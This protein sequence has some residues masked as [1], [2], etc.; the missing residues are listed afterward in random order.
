MISAARRRQRPAAVAELGEPREGG[1]HVLEG[2]VA[3]AVHAGRALMKRFSRTD[4]FEMSGLGHVADAACD[5]VGRR[6]VASRPCHCTA[7]AGRPHIAHQ[8]PSCPS[9][10]RA[11][12]ASAGSSLSVTPRSTVAVG[13]VSASSCPS[14]H[15]TASPEASCTC[16]LLRM[17]SGRSL[18]SPCPPI[19]VMRSATGHR[20][21]AGTAWPRFRRALGFLGAHAGERLVEQHACG[22]VARHIA[23]STCAAVAQ[24]AGRARARRGRRRRAPLVGDRA[25]LR[26]GRRRAA[27][28]P[29][30]AARRP[31]RTGARSR[32]RWNSLK[33]VVRW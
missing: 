26:A 8:R 3:P 2:P 31:G 11:G 28:T 9:S 27:H 13:R 5:C 24:H 20:R 29:R 32:T 12:R 15:A 7:P 33:M 19:T 4:R 6:A 30:R 22:L 1:E 21:P 14:A 23:I 18:A 25:A 17:R 16:S 10:G